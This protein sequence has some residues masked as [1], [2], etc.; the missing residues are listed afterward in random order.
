MVFLRPELTGDRVR[1]EPLQQRHAAG[2][3][4][5]STGAGDL[6][7]MTTV[8]TTEAGAGRYIALAEA[9][10]AAGTAAPFAVIRL[11]DE[12]VIGSTRLWELQW[13]A[14]P[15]SH[16]RHGHDG[17]D[18]CEIGHT[19]LAGSAIRTGANTEMKRL[20][21]TFAFETWQVQSV[22]FHTD[23]RNER[24]ARAIQRI[25]GQFEGILRSHRLAADG[26]PRDSARYSITAAEWPA[27][28]ARLAEMSASR[29][30]A[31]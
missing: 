1:L 28:R 25:G 21:L 3:V 12:M 19:W 24:S 15:E 10:R 26:R 27:V 23:A 31:S 22:C 29:A 11:A 18:T 6:Y 17:P 30:A 20:M 7:R 16:P 9:A 4:A 2:L 13:W 5:A 14:W 8:P